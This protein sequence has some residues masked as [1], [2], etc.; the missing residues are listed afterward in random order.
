[1][2]I[3]MGV[4]ALLCVLFGSVPSL[5]YQYLPHEVHYH[6]YT[7][8]H[9]VEATQ[10]LILAFAGFWLLKHR[11]AGERK[12]ILDTDFFYRRPAPWLRKYVVELT[13][14]AFRRSEILAVGL[15][16]ALTR[17]SKNPAPAIQRIATI[18]GRTIGPGEFD[19]DR[20]RPV[21]QFI[22]GLI[23]LTFVVIA[24]LLLF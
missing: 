24:L 6:P 19:P 15:V 10:I 12:L 23:L 5:L 18:P 2:L 13:E 8:P 1:M 3:G 14:R 22:T 7:L 20:A 9:L 17:I 11:L 21:V 4:L 16:H